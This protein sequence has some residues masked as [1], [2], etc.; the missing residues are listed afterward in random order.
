MKKVIN[1]KSRQDDDYAL[2]WVEG[3]LYKADF[4][5]MMEWVR[6]GGDGVNGSYDFVDP[7]GGP[8]IHI[9]YKLPTGETVESIKVDR[10]IY[11][12]LKN[13]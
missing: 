8:F 7:P 5:E 9:G 13:E 4:G 11:L 2:I 1:L 3:N 6:F 10:G 12:T